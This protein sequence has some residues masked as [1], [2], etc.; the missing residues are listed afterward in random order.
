M[1]N[2]PKPTPQAV[3]AV[4]NIISGKF[5]S[6]KEAMMDAGYS[7]TSAQHPRQALIETKGVQEYLKTLS[8]ISKRKY[9]LSLGDKVMKTYFDGLDANKRVGRDAD[10]VVEDWQARKSSADA[11][12]E[13]LGLKKG[14]APYAAGA[15]GPPINNTQFNFFSVPQEERKKWN[16]NL[17]GFLASYFNPNAGQSV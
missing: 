6:K 7:I 9:G 13:F 5:K 1:A 11:L 4:N 15:S 14:I 16:E 17:K 8:M 12:A 3:D 10:V 2:H